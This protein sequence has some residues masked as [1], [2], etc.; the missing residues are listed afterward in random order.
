MKTLAHK[1]ILNNDM[2]VHFRLTQF[3]DLNISE[4]SSLRVSYEN[5]LAH[6]DILNNIE[7]VHFQLTEF[8]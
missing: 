7:K 4:F 8:L 5:T 1:D 6:M 3:R 2:K